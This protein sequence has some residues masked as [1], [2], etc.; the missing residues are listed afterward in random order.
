[1]F[2]NLKILVTIYWTIQEAYVGQLWPLE[3]DIVLEKS[4]WHRSYSMNVQIYYKYLK[5]IV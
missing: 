2:P 1:M 5:Q 3:K 4:I